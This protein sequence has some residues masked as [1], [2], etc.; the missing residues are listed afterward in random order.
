MSAER[1]LFRS[2]LAAT[3]CLWLV[4]SLWSMPKLDA[5]GGG[6]IFDL[7]F[8]GYD[9]TAAE[10]LLRALGTEGRAFYL[11]AQQWLDTAFPAVLALTLVLWFRR[12]AGQGGGRVLS[13]LAVLGA[14]LDYAE[15]SLVRGMLASGT[16]DGVEWASR[17]TLMK[18]AVGAVV[19][20]AALLLVMA[21][22]LRQFRGRT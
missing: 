7:R 4:M 19:L 13:A 3:L 10:A 12:T 5:F 17:M 18:S 15:N 22:A 11:N 21:A 20:A 6:P 8:L 16:A 2:S 9:R 14:A 1:A